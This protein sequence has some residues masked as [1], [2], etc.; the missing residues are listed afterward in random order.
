MI[1]TLYATPLFGIALSLIAYELGLLIQR[2]CGGTPL[3]NPLLISLLILVPFIMVTGIP[4]DAYYL[5]GDVIS[6]TLV[7]VTA[8]LGLNIFKQR[9][10]LKERFI[11]IVFGCTAGCLFNVA[12]MCTVCRMV[13]LDEVLTNSLLSRSV[14]TPIALALSQQLGGLTAIT[15]VSVLVTGVTGAALSPLLVRMFRVTHPVAAGVAIG[16]SS[17]ALG[18]TTALELG[19]VQGAMSSVSIGVA[20]VITVIICLFL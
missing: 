1:E 6:L 11:P 19:E 8:V 13:G 2:L 3:A 4:L 5:G 15:M 16:T 10:I 9:A 14:T 18:T 7:P 12:F 20:G 17:H